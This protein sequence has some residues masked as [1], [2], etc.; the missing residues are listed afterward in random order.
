MKIILASGSPGRKELMEKTGLA[1]G[2]DPADFDERGVVEESAHK[3]AEI[4]ALAKAMAVAPRHLNSIIIGSDLVVAYRDKQIG[5]PK[6]EQDA[7]EILQLLRSKT[8]Q[9]ITGIAVVNTTSNIQ[10]TT[11]EIANVTMR[12]YSDRQIND[13]IATGEPMDKGGAYA[14]QGLGGKLVEKFDGD[15]ETIIGLPT[16]PLLDLI[17]KVK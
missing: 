13:Y 10:A 14:I 2:V 12:N 11:V 6:D 3:L 1:F 5:K 9:V 7:K 15:I 16:R 4:L 8:H 17:K